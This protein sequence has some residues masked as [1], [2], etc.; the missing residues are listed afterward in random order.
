MTRPR[1]HPM[2]FTTCK[3]SKLHLASFGPV[4]TVR[5]IVSVFIIISHAGSVIVPV[6]GIGRISYGHCLYHASPF[7]SITCILFP[8]SIFLHL[9]LYLLFPRLFRVLSLFYRTSTLVKQ[10]AGR[11]EFLFKNK[12]RIRLRAHD[13]ARCVDRAWNT[14]IGLGWFISSHYW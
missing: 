4:D 9:I 7:R 8:L 11:G 6:D 3:R 5:K 12:L 14:T 13:V 2:T 1:F 10:Y